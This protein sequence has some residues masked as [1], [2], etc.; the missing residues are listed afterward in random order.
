MV[1]MMKSVLLTECVWVKMGT[2]ATNPI[3][4]N[5]FTGTCR[6]GLLHCNVDIREALGEVKPDKWEMNSK[7]ILDVHAC[8]YTLKGP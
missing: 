6:L 3:T 7:V 8:A 2:S 1:T 5:P 4:E